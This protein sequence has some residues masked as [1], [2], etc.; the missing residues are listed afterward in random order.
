ML[1]KP[2]YSEAEKKLFSKLGFGSLIDANFVEPLALYRLACESVFLGNRQGSIVEALR[3][4][5]QIVIGSVSP[6]RRL[7]PEFD[8]LI[9]FSE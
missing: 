8:K 5:A 7:T 6:I 4:G 9:E 3:R 2:Q 1:T